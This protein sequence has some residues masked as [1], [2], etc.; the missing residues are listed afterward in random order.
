MHWNLDVLARWTTAL[1]GGERRHP[2]PS[3]GSGERPDGPLT[4]FLWGLLLH[5]DKLWRRIW[6]DLTDWLGAVAPLVVVASVTLAAVALFVIT[7]IRLRDRRLTRDGRR[8]RILP[9]PDVPVDGASVLWTALH[10][11]I[12]PRW[13]QL[14]MGQPSLAWEVVA[15]SD[16]TEISLWVPGVVP[17]HLVERALD[18]AW[19]GASL[20]E[21]ESDDLLNPGD[22]LLAGAQMTL[23]RAEWFPI[24]TGPDGDPLR[25]AL[26]SLAAA[27]EGDTT[28]M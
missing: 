12:R 16:E 19:P 20:V 3:P 10:G 15:Q 22:G 1:A 23:A 9:P 27:P 14:L 21:A 25:V 8:I 11:L 28:L 5:P 7:L 24:G 13:K 2:R 26:S 6:G 17:L 18:A 4:G